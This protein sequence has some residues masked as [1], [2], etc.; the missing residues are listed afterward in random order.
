MTLA[1]SAPCPGVRRPAAIASTIC[2]S[3][4]RAC[5][6][7]LIAE[8]VAGP[9]H[10]HTASSLNSLA[11]CL[12]AQGDFAGALPLRERA[13]AICEKVLGPQHPDTATSLSG[14]AT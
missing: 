4:T 12:A 2:Q 10:P 5:I 7:D 3:T 1:K 9:E 6:G 13:L 11:S 14:L 8:K